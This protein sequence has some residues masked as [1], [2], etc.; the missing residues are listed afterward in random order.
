MKRTPGDF[1]ESGLDDARVERLWQG[2]GRRLEARPARA[3]WVLALGTVVVAAGVA[4]FLSLG[5]LPTA[6]DPPTARVGLLE[7]TETPVQQ[8]LDDGSRLELKARSR[9]TLRSNRPTA[10]ALELSRGEVSCDVSHRSGR[11]F[12]VAAAGLE[13]RVVGTR[14]SVKAEPAS[15]GSRV[16]VRV[17]EGTVEVRRVGEASLLARV[18]AGQTWSHVPELARLVADAPPLPDVQPPSPPAAPV[19]SSAAAAERA[20]PTARDLFEKAGAQRRAGDAAGAARAYEELLREHPRDARAGLAAFELGRLRM[21]RLGDSAGAIGALERAISLG[22]STSFR[23][24]ALARLVVAYS[25]QGNS[26]ACARARDGYLRS[27]PHGVH[28]TAVAASCVR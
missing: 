18:G 11:T 1:V 16:D 2:V 8:A 19:A 17:H 22:V 24:D 13:V 7:A 9:V 20:G 25:S 3:R 4:L 10:V 15:G 12:T 26:A 21:D 27:Y 14:F 6:A 28:A 23:E 5:S